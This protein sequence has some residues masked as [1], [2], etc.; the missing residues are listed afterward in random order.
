MSQYSIIINNDEINKPL[1]YMPKSTPPKITVEM[2][3]RY[4]RNIYADLNFNESSYF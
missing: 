2:I 4:T 1:E 3:N